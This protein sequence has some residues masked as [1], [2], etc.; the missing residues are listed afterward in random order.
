MYIYIYMYIHIYIYM[1][2]HT[3]IY[4]YVYIHTRTHTINLSLSLYIYIYKGLAQIS[5][6]DRTLAGNAIH[7]RGLLRFWQAALRSCALIA[8]CKLSSPLLFLGVYFDFLLRGRAFGQ[9]KSASFE[10]QLVNT[11]VCWLPFNRPITRRLAA[12]SLTLSS[13]LLPPPPGLAGLHH[14]FNRNCFAV[15]YLVS[16]WSLLRSFS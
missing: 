4:I 1:Y 16:P 6:N 5:S 11:W 7:S 8:L 3:H 9:Q 12:S 14:L 10:S 13:L 2:I 15:T